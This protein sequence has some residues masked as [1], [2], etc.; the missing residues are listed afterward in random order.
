MTSPDRWHMATMAGVASLSWRAAVLALVAILLGAAATRPAAAHGP[1]AGVPE[2][3]LRLSETVGDVVADLESFVPEYLRAEEVPG[4]AVALIRDGKVVWTEGYGVANAITGEPVTP[5]TLFEVASNSKVV[6]AYV[7]LRLVDQGVL[8][9]DEPLNAYLPEPWLHPS[10]YQD[11]ITL[12]HVLSH[13]SG[14]GHGTGEKDVRFVPGSGYSYSAGGYLYLQEVIEAVTGRSLDAVAEE[15]VFEPLGMSS[16]SFV[17]RAETS[18]RTANGHTRAAAPVLLFLVFFVASASVVCLAGLTIVRISTGRWRPTLRMVLGATVGALVLASL[19]ALLLLSGIGLPKY[20]WLVLS[21]GWA[22]AVACGLA[23]WVGW[24]ILSRLLAERTGA[25]RA[26][27]LVW[28]AIVLA[29]LVALTLSATNVPMPKGLPVEASAA[30]TVRTAAGDLAVFLSELSDPQH[31]TSDLAAEMQS[32]QVTLSRDLSWGL[33]PGI[34]HSNEG[35]ALWQW[36]QAPGFQSVM[37]VY[38]ERGAGV[39]VLTNNDW[40]NPDVAI[41]IAHRAMGGKIE[42]LRR[43]THREFDYSGPFLEK[44]RK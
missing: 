41:A 31:L 8:S 19:A 44:A 11:E 26:L 7:A 6:T 15:M 23:V 22:L 24:K 40:F 13:T 28:S 25:R 3:P 18:A 34:Q 33:G 16:S 27:T 17:H 12:R 36:G 43:A 9:L 10:E 30:G 1:D 29:G 42:P 20:G 4:A 2:S 39:V 37:M 38:P 14:L 21:C 35:D 32:S 5:D